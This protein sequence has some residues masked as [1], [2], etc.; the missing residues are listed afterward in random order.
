MIYIKRFLYTTLYEDF[1]NSSSYKE[2]CV[3]KIG[4]PG[5]NDESTIVKYNLAASGGQQ[6]VYT[7][8]RHWDGT[9]NPSSN[10]WKDKIAN[11]YWSLSGS[12]THGTGYYE[13]ANTNPASASKYGTLNGTLPDLGYHWKI[14][15]DVA[16]QTRSSNPTT[17][18][19]ID[20]GSVGSV[21]AGKC[22]V[23][24]GWSSGNGKF[25]PNAKFN[26]NDSAPTYNPDFA[27]MSAESITTSQVWIRRTVSFGVRASGIS[28]KDIMFVYIPEKGEAV[29]STPFTPIRFN[30]W[31]SSKSFLARSQI[32]PSNSYK[33]STYCRIYDIK[34]YGTA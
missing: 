29:T 26:G 11:Q 16:F 25:A 17:F 8:L 24:C 9:T 31:E 5:V 6:E 1:K 34:V 7:L 15:A 28:G 18:I 33:F 20:F 22:A 23:C 30:R 32:A 19:P 27:T 12:P 2:P 10:Q 14:V 3:I 4:T 21:S 13:F